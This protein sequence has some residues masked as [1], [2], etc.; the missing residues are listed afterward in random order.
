M[1]RPQYDRYASE[2]RAPGGGAIAPYPIGGHVVNG[3]LIDF[4]DN[5]QLRYGNVN[6]YHQLL[7]AQQQQPLGYPQQQAQPGYPPVMPQQQQAQPQP[8]GY[9]VP[10][11]A[12]PAMLSGPPSYIHVNGV[13]YKPV[14]EP[15]AEPTAAAAAAAPDPSSAHAP[16]PL[17]EE[18]LNKAIDHRVSVVAEDYISR[19]LHRRSF[20]QEP[21]ESAAPSISRHRAAPA[22]HTRPTMARPEARPSRSTAS[23][24]SSDLEAALDRVRSAVASLPADPAPVSTH[25]RW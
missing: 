21:S 3:G 19:K 5:S 2:A 15:P 25:R 16:R 11:V 7:A 13:T 17:T 23:S 6:D 14:T 24:S 4:Q 18:E 22:H 8:G 10:N 9:P 12:Q 1:S 20:S